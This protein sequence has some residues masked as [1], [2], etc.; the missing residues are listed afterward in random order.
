[1]I[2]ECISVYTKVGLDIY[3][4]GH[5]IRMYLGVHEG[6]YNMLQSMSIIINM[7]ID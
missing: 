1:M 4:T 3:L 6:R 7:Y 2:L 5:G